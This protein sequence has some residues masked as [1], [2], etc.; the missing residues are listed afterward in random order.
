MAL[1]GDGSIQVQ[2]GETEIGQGAD[3]VFSQMAADASGVRMDMVHLVSFQD[4]DVTPVGLGAYGS[5]QTYAAGYSIRKTATLLKEKI[6]SA[7]KNC[8]RSRHPIW[9]SQTERS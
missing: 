7:Q 1:N 2:M 4:T 5:R 9:I 3:T 8:C 6:L